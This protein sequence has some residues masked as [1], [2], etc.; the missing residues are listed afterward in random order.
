MR[1]YSLL[2][3]LVTLGCVAPALPRYSR[4]VPAVAPDSEPAWLADDSTVS[5]SGY[6]KRVIL[7][8]FRAGASQ[9]QRQ[10][11]IDLSGG[12]VIGGMRGVGPDGFYIVYIP[13]AETSAA[14]G[15]AIAR[16]KNLTQVELVALAWTGDVSRT[17]SRLQPPP[18]DS[19]TA[20]PSD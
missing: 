6:W 7:V 16:L 14:L 1:H 18:V 4:N 20:P 10:A 19:V 2:T 15:A 17:P 13:R 8:L 11:A 9:A 12:Y 3:L 5:Q